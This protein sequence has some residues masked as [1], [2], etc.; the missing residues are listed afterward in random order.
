VTIDVKY[1]GKA[2]GVVAQLLIKP[3]DLVKVGQQVTSDVADFNFDTVIK[4]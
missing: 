2:P 1:T 3:S 4:H